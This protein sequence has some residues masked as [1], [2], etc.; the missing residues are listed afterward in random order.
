MRFV[1]DE[2]YPPAIA[3]MLSVLAAA[4]STLYEVTSVVS[5]GMRS[6]TDAE[7]LAAICKGAQRG[8]LITTDKKLRSRP[9]EQKV[10]KD[11]GAIAV[12]GV[13]NWNQQSDLWLRSGM[14]LWW[15]PWI[16]K[17]VETTDPASFLELPWNRNPKALRR[18]RAR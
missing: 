6:A 7:I 2:N 18:W 17:T 8:V 14:M 15:W 5:I 11:E 4:E 9:H 3:K 10:I 1:F 16:V 12:V 13:K